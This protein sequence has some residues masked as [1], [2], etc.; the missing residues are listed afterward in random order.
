[1]KTLVIGLSGQLASSFKKVD[2][3]NKF[4][5]V[6]QNQ[7]DYQNST[8]IYQILKREKPEVIINCAAYTLVDLAES[9]KEK[10]EKLN[11]EF[12]KYIIDWCVEYNSKLIHFSTDY[13]FDGIKQGEY[14]E[15]DVVSPANWYGETKAQAEKL[16]MNSA[17]QAVIFRIS[18]LYSE[19]GN[20]FLKTMIRLGKEKEV[21][22]IVSDQV[23]SPC[24]AVNVA[25]VVYQ[26]INS[27]NL[28]NFKKGI[29][30]LV[31]PQQISWFQFAKKIFYAYEKTHS[32]LKV[33]T[34][35]P[36]LSADY[37]TAARR[38]LN[39]RL[40]ALKARDVLNLSLEDLDI[41]LQKACKAL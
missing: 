18:W 26:W 23:G 25:E 31:P 13:V 11:V 40:C 32:D 2:L 14:T 12:V 39:S 10:C 16:I 3:K 21:L 6:G 37:K 8:S 15:Q 19:Y 34:V 7:F 38:P 9:E 28:N 20:N 33:K 41:S 17:A 22:N 36:I 30:H 29:Y 1:M 35:N 27:H 24:Y 4:V 5:F